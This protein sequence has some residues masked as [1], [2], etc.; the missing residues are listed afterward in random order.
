MLGS[1]ILYLKG[2]RTIFF[3]L[4]GFYYKMYKT[5]PPRAGLWPGESDAVRKSYLLEG[6]L[7]D[8]VRPLKG[9]MGFRSL[10]GSIGFMV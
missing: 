8:L 6:A 3:Q 1:L 5:R 4:S 2:M 9:S 7:G 10:K